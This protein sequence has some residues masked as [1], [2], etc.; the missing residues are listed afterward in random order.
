LPTVTATLKAAVTEQGH[1]ILNEFES[2]YG[3]TI[4]TVKFLI[5]FGKSG[6]AVL[7]PGSGEIQ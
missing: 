1:W 5:L 2:S 4:M 7:A 6:Q 3:T